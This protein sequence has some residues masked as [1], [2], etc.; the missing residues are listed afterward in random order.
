MLNQCFRRGRHPSRPTVL[1]VRLSLSL[2]ICRDLSFFLERETCLG[3]TDEIGI[4]LPNSQR[5]HLT[6]HA[7]KDVLPL[8]MWGRRLMRF[9]PPLLLFT[10]AFVYVR[11]RER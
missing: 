1:G 6:L 10:A 5:Q 4:L 8:R 7:P 9:I 11:A 3:G 2:S